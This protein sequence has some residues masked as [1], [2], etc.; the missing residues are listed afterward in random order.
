[1]FDY[2]AKADAIL[3]QRAYIHNEHRKLLVHCIEE[4]GHR[5]SHYPHPLWDCKYAMLRHTLEEH[6]W[7]PKFGAIRNRKFETH[8]QQA[9]PRPREQ[10]VLPTGTFYIKAPIPMEAQALYDHI[11]SSP[12]NP[13]TPTKP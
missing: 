10:F 5:L 9:R 2:R 11:M 7:H 13:N 1:M 12:Y 4:R 6:E 3:R 8:A